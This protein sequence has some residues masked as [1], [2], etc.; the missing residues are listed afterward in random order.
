[1]DP[2][3]TASLIN[4]LGFTVGMALYALLLAMVIRHRQAPGQVSEKFPLDFLF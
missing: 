4:L 1:M 3:N 2:F